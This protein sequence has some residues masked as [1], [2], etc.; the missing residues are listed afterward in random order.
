MI[1]KDGM[2]WFL[3]FI[4]SN[5]TP[6]KLRVT[7]V[8]AEN[9]L[10]DIKKRV[11]AVEH[12]HS[13][14]NSAKFWNIQL[15][16]EAV[17]FQDNYKGSLMGIYRIELDPSTKEGILTVEYSKGVMRL[18]LGLFM[19]LVIGLAIGFGFWY[20]WIGLFFGSP[21]LFFLFKLRNAEERNERFAHKEVK[22][23]I[24]HLV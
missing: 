2:N 1:K 4:E 19:F 22:Y 7:F 8:P 10:V 20:L 6:S 5:M 16:D 11:E 15:S 3:K 12:V 13:L 21:S 14:G 9:N 18:Y 24:D 17:T 23:V